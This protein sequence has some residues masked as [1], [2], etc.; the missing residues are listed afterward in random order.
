MHSG[1]GWTVALVLVALAVGK[2]VDRAVPGAHV[3]VGL[4]LAGC[5][6]VI[7]RAAGL[8]AAGLG[9]ARSTWPAGLWWG[10]AAATLVGAGYAL[11]YL[12]TS[13]RQAL[14]ES[15]GG[16]GARCCGRCWS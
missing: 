8:A 15:D 14:P 1:G 5:L 7:A 16:I 4:A 6:L 3:A 9:L 10:A 13:V 11:A 2:A 12:I